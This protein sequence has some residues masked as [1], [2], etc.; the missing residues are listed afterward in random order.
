M[1]S[2]Y[3]IGIAGSLRSG[4]YNK[5]LIRNAARLAPDAMRI[6]LID[7]GDVAPYNADLDKDGIRPAPVERLKRTVADADALLIST[8]EYN[9]SVPGVLQNAIDW[10]SRPAGNSP[11]VNKPIGIIG[12]SMGALGAVRAQQQLK[13]VLASTLSHVMPHAGVS[14]GVVQ[15][16]ID[17]AGELHDEQ[18]RE[19]LRSFLLQLQHYTERFVDRQSKQSAA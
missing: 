12:A 4:S 7:I 15:N 2:L 18:T 13:L 17:S 19:F 11:L 5:M 3:V 8:P 1:R 10:V 16:K 14:V 6:E 9:H